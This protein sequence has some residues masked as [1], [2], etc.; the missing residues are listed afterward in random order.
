MPHLKYDPERHIW[1]ALSPLAFI[2]W[3]LIARRELDAM[4]C[5]VKMMRNDVIRTVQ[6]PKMYVPVYVF[7][8]EKRRWV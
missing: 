7:K 5:Q 4:T 1:I 8:R 3:N 6:S 2:G